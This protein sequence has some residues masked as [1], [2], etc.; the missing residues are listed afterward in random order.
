MGRATCT[1]CKM[2]WNRLFDAFVNGSGWTRLCGSCCDGPRPDH[3]EPRAY[4]GRY[5]I[6]ADFSALAR[7]PDPEPSFT[8]PE[9]Q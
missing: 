8:I 4:L 1:R 6:R 2:G 5:P 7:Q 9:L 3:P